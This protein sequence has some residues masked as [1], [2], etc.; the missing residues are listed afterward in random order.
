MKKSHVKTDEVKG[1][2]GAYSFH[3]VPRLNKALRRGDEEAFR[4]L[5]TQWNGRLVR[6]CFVIARGDDAVANELAQAT[7]LRLMRHIRPL[8]DEYALW[9]WMARAARSAAADRHRVGMR[10]SKALARLGD[11][12]AGPKPEQ[13]E[14][15]TES[16][17]YT[18]LDRV[19]D[20]LDEE[21]Q[22]LIDR[23]YFN[24]VPLET[25]GA[26]LN[27]SARAIEGRLARLRKKIHQRLQLCMN[28]ETAR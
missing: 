8:P 1:A 3:D 20:E 5:H 11:W 15:K 17:L 16:A 21:E 28:E 24:P 6:Y 12:M 10:Y 27:C 14:P 19:L 25:I 7:Y 2:G 4:W 9:A 13:V 18:L 22:F 23:R 26:E